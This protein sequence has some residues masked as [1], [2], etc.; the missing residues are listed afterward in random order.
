MVDDDGGA[1]AFEIGGGDALAL[2][3]E[4][5]FALDAGD[6]S[7]QSE[8]PSSLSIPQGELVDGHVTTY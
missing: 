3:V 4:T 2:E 7:V 5:L 1:V 6:K 8:H